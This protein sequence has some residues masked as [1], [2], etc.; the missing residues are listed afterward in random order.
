MTIERARPFPSAGLFWTILQSVTYAANEATFSVPAVTRNAFGI[1]GTNVS[2]WNGMGQS[3]TQLVQN[4]LWVN[5]TATVTTYNLGTQEFSASGVTQVSNAGQ[6]S[7][8]TPSSGDEIYSEIWYCD[9]NGNVNTAGG[10]ACRQMHDTTSG[11]LWACTA[12]NG[13]TCSSYALNP[14]DVV[15]GNLGTSAEFVIENDG[16]EVPGDT[17]GYW[18]DFAAPQTMD[19]F[20]PN[21]TQVSIAQGATGYIDLMMGGPSRGAR[22]QRLRDVH[23]LDDHAGKCRSDD[24]R[25][26]DRSGRPRGVDTPDHAVACGVGQLRDHGDRAGLNVRQESLPHGFRERHAVSI[27]RVWRELLWADREQQWL[28]WHISRRMRVLPE[29]LLLLGQPMLP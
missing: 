5:S 21:P 18:P 20:Y 3:S 2:I 28:R 23:R 4:E 10:Y 14:A 12:A 25:W 13:A 11:A 8:F 24:I 27:R 19:I 17:Q 16:D 22:Q 7:K 6:G 15:N 26:D 9:A 1:S 29:R